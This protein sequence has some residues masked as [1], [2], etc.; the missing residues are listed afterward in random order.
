MVHYFRK[1]DKALQTYSCN[2][3]SVFFFL[4]TGIYSVEKY[5]KKPNLNVACQIIV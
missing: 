2:Y 5:S 3:S 4:F 1:S